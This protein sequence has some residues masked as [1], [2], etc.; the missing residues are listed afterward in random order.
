MLKKAACLKLVW[1]L[2]LAALLMSCAYSL[3][4]SARKYDPSDYSPYDKPG[5]ASLSGEVLIGIGPVLAKEYPPPLPSRVL[6]KKSLDQQARQ[7]N[8]QYTPSTKLDAEHGPVCTVVLHPITKYSEDWFSGQFLRK[9]KHPLPPYEQQLDSRYVQKCKADSQGRFK[10]EN[11]A[12]GQ[13]LLFTVLPS[14]EPCWTRVEVS[15]GTNK[16]AI[17]YRQISHK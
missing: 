14:G 4:K 2:M 15:G 17:L 8:L 12:P 11:L 3:Q 7:S 16:H 1:L 9:R 13:Y 10:F 6:D 5:T